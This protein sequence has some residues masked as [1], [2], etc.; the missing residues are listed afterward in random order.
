MALEA[1]RGNAA[2]GGSS[3]GT[4]CCSTQCKQERI[5][6]NNQQHDNL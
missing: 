4:R 3:T 1:D 6:N 5:S 2:V